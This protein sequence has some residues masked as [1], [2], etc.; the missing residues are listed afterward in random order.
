LNTLLCDRRATVLNGCK[1]VAVRF[2]TDVQN[3]LQ[4]LLSAVGAAA[5]GGAELTARYIGFGE[6]PLVIL[7][8]KIE[9]YLA[10]SRSY[11]RFG[12]D[13]LVNRYSMRSEDVDK[14]NLPPHYDDIHLSKDGARILSERLAV[15]IGPVSGD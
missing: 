15:D 12:H 1:R 13:I 3:V 7:D 6:P 10:P 11:T 5:I 4:P 14:L 9:Y 2:D 8:S